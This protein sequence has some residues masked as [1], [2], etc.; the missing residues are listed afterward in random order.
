MAGFKSQD[1]I[2][3]VS[4]LDWDRPNDI[5]IIIIHTKDIIVASTGCERESAREVSADG[6]PQVFLVECC[7][8]AS[9]MVS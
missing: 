3:T 1:E 8:A 2:F 7:Y 5:G 4:G 6:A 9:Y